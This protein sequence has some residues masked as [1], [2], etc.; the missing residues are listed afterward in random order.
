[1]KR[2]EPLR[3]QRT[4][5]ACEPQN[6]F[7]FTDQDRDAVRAALVARARADDAV[8]AAAFTGSYASAAVDRWSDV[9]VVLAV[10]D[11]RQLDEVAD[12]CTRWLYVERGA[13]H[14]WDLPGGA[15]RIIRVALLPG[16]LE[17]DL[18]F[19]TVEQFGA[20]GPQWRTVFGRSRAD[21]DPF[22]PAQRDRLIG[23]GWHHLLH[24]RAAIERDRCWQAEQWI[25]AARGQLLSLACQRLG[26]PAEY[27]KTAHLLPAEVTAPLP[28]TLVRELSGS[29]LRRALA[30][31]TR[32]F[33]DELRRI[34]RDLADRVQSQL[35][36][37]IS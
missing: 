15:G 18:N 27:G 37:L 4:V 13:V 6:C 26:Y 24:A 28:A 22:P 3:Q 7:V 34:D 20:R 14:H 8:C 36:D 16:A 12:G 2:Y 11:A 21:L 30:A 33:L 5:G 9:D 23:L 32:A 10:R 1:M 35:N 31:T 17:V 25:S 19:V 29:E